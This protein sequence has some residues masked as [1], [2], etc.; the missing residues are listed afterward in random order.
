MIWQQTAAGFLLNFPRLFGVPTTT[1]FPVPPSPLLSSMALAEVETHTTA[2]KDVTS[3]QRVLS[4]VS[5]T[6]WSVI[7][8]RWYGST[9]CSRGSK[10]FCDRKQTFGNGNIPIN[11]HPQGVPLRKPILSGHP[12]RVPCR[13]HVV[14]GQAHPTLILATGFL[15]T[16][17]LVSSP[18]GS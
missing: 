18:K 16:S 5:P 12:L 4:V 11:G 6:D 15:P 7:I 14:V 17:G 1:P 10:T 8:V 13:H 9:C 3:R 2:P